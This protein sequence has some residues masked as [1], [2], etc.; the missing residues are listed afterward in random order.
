MTKFNNLI[1]ILLLFV[2]ISFAWINN[3]SGLSLNAPEITSF[4]KSKEED[5]ALK[6]TYKTNNTGSNYSIEILNGTTLKKDTISGVNTSYTFQNLINGKEYVVQIRACTNSLNNYVCSNW[7]NTV[8][9]TADS[10]SFINN[11]KSVVLNKNIFDYTGKEIKPSVIVKDIKG[12]VLTKDVD[13]TVTY[14]KDLA[15][16]GAYKVIVTGKN[17]YEFTKELTYKVVLGTPQITRLMPTEDRID[18]GNTGVKNQVKEGSGYQIA[19]KKSTDSSY[20]KFSS[21]GVI[22]KGFPKKKLSPSTKYN[23][24]VRAF[25]KINGKKV[26]GPWSKTV[27]IKTLSKNNKYSKTDMEVSIKGYNY[28]YTGN[29]RKPKVTVKDYNTKKVLKKGTDYTVT[30]SDNCSEVG[31]YTIKIKGKGKYS[32][33]YPQYLKYNIY[34]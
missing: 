17:G 13:Y 3:V 22:P 14:V 9:E 29:N 21:T 26:Y 16:I 1:F 24:K 25:N 32:K 11:I 30:Y 27:S 28:K 8:S 4:T 10:R 34:K 20:T 31:L 5:N 19:Y 2:V 23:I 7:S 12:K 15:K 6:L 18:V 33:N